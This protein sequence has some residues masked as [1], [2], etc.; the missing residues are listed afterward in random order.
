MTA[1]KQSFSRCCHP[2][3][4]CIIAWIALSACAPVR[5]TPPEV[6]LAGVEISDISIT[7]LN[8]NAQLRIYNPNRVSIKIGAINY[9]MD[10]NGQRIFSSVTYV[11]DSLGPGDSMVVPL[12]I[13]SAFW[14]LIALFSRMGRTEALDF[15]ISGSVEAGKSLG[16]MSTFDFERTGKLDIT[17]PVRRGGGLGGGPHRPAPPHRYQVPDRGPQDSSVNHKTEDYI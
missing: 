3:L 6:E 14:D 17:D 8:L 10:V 11:D 13:S 16:R 4:A 15:R 2:I 9:S 12:R 5:I 7:H 1:N